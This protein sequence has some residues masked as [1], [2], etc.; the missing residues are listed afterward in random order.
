[1]IASATTTTPR[2]LSVVLVARVMDGVL[3]IRCLGVF[4][5]GA[6]L[7]DNPPGDWT[8]N[9]VDVFE[10]IEMNVPTFSYTFAAKKKR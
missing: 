9:V 2:I 7:P 10:G 4:P 1:M 8:R 3:R 6:K 5:Q